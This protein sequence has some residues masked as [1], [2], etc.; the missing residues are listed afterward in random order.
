MSKSNIDKINLVKNKMREDIKSIH[1][2]IVGEALKFVRN[3]DGR[4]NVNLPDFRELVASLFE[5][6]KTGKNKEAS[7]ISFAETR[8]GIQ[9]KIN[10]L[11]MNGAN[12][13]DFNDVLSELSVEEKDLRKQLASNE[14]VQELISERIKQQL[15]SSPSFFI[16]D[17]QGRVT[18]MGMAD[19]TALIGKLMPC[20]MMPDNLQPFLKT[21]SQDLVSPSI[22]ASMAKFFSKEGRLN[23]DCWYVMDQ[24]LVTSKNIENFGKEINA[25]LEAFAITEQAIGIIESQ[26]WKVSQ[27]QRQE[28]GKHL[29]GKFA[30]FGSDYL[31]GHG[32]ELVK[33]VAESLKDNRSWWSMIFSSYSIGNSKLD[34]IAAQV[35]AK[36]EPAVNFERTLV[37]LE[38]S[39]AQD[40]SQEN[41][42]ARNQH[43]DQHKWQDKVGKKQNQELGKSEKWSDQHKKK[44]DKF[45]ERLTK[46]AEILGTQVKSK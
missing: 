22:Q 11:I 7:V 12:Q 30:E 32:Q 24:A 41:D 33:E 13:A 42:K 16:E 9:D 37:K 15:L 28:I 3:N 40:K 17:Q 10:I 29:V 18:G 6:T 23:P 35:T 4:I 36:H 2:F 14:G 38:Q 44:D 21:D 27:K 46:E 8:N 26:G 25:N 1:G 20:V 43:K 39:G 34:K 5:T 45:T 19:K 31:R